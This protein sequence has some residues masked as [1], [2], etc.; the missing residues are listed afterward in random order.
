MTRG[1]QFRVESMMLRLARRRNYAAVS[2]SASQGPFIY[3]FHTIV[4]FLSPLSTSVIHTIQG[5]AERLGSGLVNFELPLLHEHAC[6][7][8]P[9]WP[10]PFSRAL[11][12]YL[13]LSSFG[14]PYVDV[15]CEPFRSVRAPWPPSTSR[16]SWSPSPGSTQTP[17][18]SSTF[19][20]RFEHKTDISRDLLG[21][22]S[23]RTM[24]L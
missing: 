15:T 21:L 12:I 11:Y 18:S 19:R 10:N 22:S 8:H 7:I 16:S 1:S 9:T 3:D 17:S 6:S 23:C 20:C 5:W 24:T 14:G 2:P 4:I 13:T